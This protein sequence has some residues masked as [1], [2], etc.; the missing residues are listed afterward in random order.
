MYNWTA[1]LNLKNCNSFKLGLLRWSLWNLVIYW[2]AKGYRICSLEQY[3]RFNGTAK[4]Y[5][6]VRCTIYFISNK[7]SN[8]VQ[9][10]VN[11]NSIS[12]ILNLIT[13]WS[14]LST[15]LVYFYVWTLSWTNVIPSLAGWP[16]KQV[17]DTWLVPPLKRVRL[18]SWLL[19][20]VFSLHLYLSEIKLFFRMLDWIASWWIIRDPSRLS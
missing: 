6:D 3:H 4:I 16:M 14:W 9:Y 8:S 10:F 5:K 12:I 18:F 20:I 1:K 19:F 13:A 15:W 11:C 2:M 17:W 7:N